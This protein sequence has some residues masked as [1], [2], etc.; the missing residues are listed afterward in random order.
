[1]SPGT[2]RTYGV[3]L[4]QS[5]TGDLVLGFLPKWVNRQVSKGEPNMSVPN[6]TLV[7][8]KNRKPSKKGPDKFLRIHWVIFQTGFTLF[9]IYE[10]VRFLKFLWLAW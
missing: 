10:L 4:L 3:Y 1:M 2:A 5:A 7:P 6:S 9:A 8:K